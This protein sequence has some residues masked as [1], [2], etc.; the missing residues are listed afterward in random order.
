MKT[1]ID[2]SGTEIDTGREQVR[3]SALE[4]HGDTLEDFLRFAILRGES[5]CKH[6][7]VWVSRDFPLEAFS[8]K[9]E[10]EW[11]T[12]LL[13]AWNEER[14]RLRHVVGVGVSTTKETSRE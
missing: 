7:E 2:I 13:L 6:R 1:K 5:Y 9:R 8:V 4:A 11:V 3:L 10:Q 12:L 14:G